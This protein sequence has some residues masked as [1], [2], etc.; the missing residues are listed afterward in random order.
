MRDQGFLVGLK[1]GWEMGLRRATGAVF[2][3]STRMVVGGEH[4]HPNWVLGIVT[5]Q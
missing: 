2:R 3:V 5:V 4:R 1:M